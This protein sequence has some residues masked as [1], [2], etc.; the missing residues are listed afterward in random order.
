MWRGAL[1]VAIVA[2][3]TWLGVS[4]AQQPSA[5]KADQQFTTDVPGAATGI[6]TTEFFPDGPNGQVKAQRG[7][8]IIYPPGTVFD[9][10]AAAVCRASEAEMQQQGLGACPADSKLGEGTADVYTTG[11]LT[12]TGPV[13]V[14]VTAFNTA[15]PKDNPSIKGGVLLAFSSHGAVTSTT[16]INTFGNEQVEKTTP[17]CVPPG[18][19]PDCPFGEFAPKRLKLDVPA[20]SKTI[21]GVVHNGATTPAVCP[22]SGH[23]TIRHTHFFA[24]GTDATYVNDLPCKQTPPRPLAVKVRPGRVRAG[25]VASFRV[26][27]TSARVAVPAARVR[28]GRRL[29]RTDVDGRASVRLPVYRPGLH[30]VRASAAG[31]V[32]TSTRFRAV[33]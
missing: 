14:D 29:L 23:W 11:T 12:P 3:F 10:S 7:T 13:T 4:S 27:V 33:R 8:H 31:Y 2:A 32:R 28:V 25:R 15:E 6:L 18:Q 9:G 30:V 24:D 17:K 21:D 26:L 16:L 22:A 19:P 1:L 5:G 20:R